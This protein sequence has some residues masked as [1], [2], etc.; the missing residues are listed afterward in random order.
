MI[1]DKQSL[2]ERNKLIAEDEWDIRKWSRIP[3]WCPLLKKRG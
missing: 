3:D 1:E 2:N